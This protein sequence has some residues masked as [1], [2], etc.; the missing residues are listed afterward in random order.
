[1][2]R[3]LVLTEHITTGPFEEYEISDDLSFGFTHGRWVELGFY[4]FVENRRDSE[5]V[6]SRGAAAMKCRHNKANSVGSI[7]MRRCT[8]PSSPKTSAVSATR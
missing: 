8:H 4:H 6:V 2:C 1:M 3:E 5:W 7:R